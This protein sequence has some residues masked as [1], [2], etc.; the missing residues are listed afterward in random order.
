MHLCRLRQGSGESDADER[1][2][3]PADHTGTIA[4]PFVNMPKA[5]HETGAARFMAL[6][7]QGTASPLDGLHRQIKPPPEN[8]AVPFAPANRRF[9]L[10]APRFRRA[11]LLLAVG[12]DQV[13]G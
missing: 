9:P 11:R 3:A 12:A 4:G 6:L 10:V 13:V 5:S 7:D 1:E 2:L 8:V